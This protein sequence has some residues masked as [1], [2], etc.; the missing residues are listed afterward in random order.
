M[1]SGVELAHLDRSVR[2]CDDF[3]RFANGGWLAT[4]VIPPEERAWG[5]FAE[6]RDRN[7][8][9]LREILEEAAARDH[10]GGSSAQ[11]VGDLFAS[12]MDEAAI[13]R[14]GIEPIAADLARIDAAR[15]A[16]ERIAVLASL[17]RGRTFP[18]FSVTVLPDAKD[19]R[20]TLLQLQQGGLGLPDRDYYLKDDA[21]SAELRTKYEEHVARMLALLG[22]ERSERDAQTILRLET[23]LAHA[24]MS[25][26]DQRVPENV[27]NKVSVAELSSRAPGLDWARYLGALGA[28][29][30][31]VNARQPAFFTELAAMAREE[32]PED[33]RTYLRWHL[34]HARAP[35]LPARFED[36]DFAFFHREL[37]GVPEQHP[38]WRRVLE[39]VDQRVGEALGQLYVARAF[40]PEAKEKVL[41]MVEDLRAALGERI[42]GL[43]WMTDA[44]KEEALRKLRSFRVKMGYPDRWR[45][46]TGLELDR[47][48]YCVNVARADELETRRLL[49]KLGKP[50]DREEWRMSP[51]TVNAYYASSYNEIVFPAGILQPPLFDPAADD[52]VN[53]GAI[54]MVI[55]HEMTHGFDD[56]GSKFDAEGN[57]R[58]WWRVED[59]ATYTARTDQVVTQFDAY[60]PLPGQRVNGR[61]TLGENIADLGGLKIAFSAFMRS[62][63]ARARATDGFTPEQ[64]FFLGFAQGWRSVWRDEAMRVRLNIDPH[65]PPQLRC[66]GP[67][68]NLPEFLQAFGCDAGSAMT[69]P[70]EVRPAIW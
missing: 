62:A 32:S 22:R 48:A 31:T 37:H 24:S 17:H 1:G 2:P 7:H 19:S 70:P 43:D 65:S 60:E 16:E 49:A 13:E 58:E 18:G 53:Y 64:R 33:W 57:L 28:R 66:N 9:I 29:E 36:E 67:L 51:P 27:Y 41:A 63:R 34:L 69:R 23:R 30:D 44:T 56:A 54:G 61:L 46:Y 38:R 8:A 10:A 55:G 11:L 52:A 42:R 25:R 21:R 12:G 40:P 47:A 59:R 5:A 3:Y 15:G 39:T 50:V 4:A 45:D 26:V 68:S 35:Y 6:I 20:S 14:A